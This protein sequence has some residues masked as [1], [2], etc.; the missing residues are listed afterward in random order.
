MTDRSGTVPAS[1]SAMVWAPA[2]AASVPEPGRYVLLLRPAPA[3]L[4][5]GGTAFGMSARHM[6]RVEGDQVLVDCADKPDSE[7]RQRAVTLPR[8]RAALG[9]Q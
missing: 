3:E 8:L 2:S 1:G 7:K 6:L 9:R 5:D 4:R